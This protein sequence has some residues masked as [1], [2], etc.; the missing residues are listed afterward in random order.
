MLRREGWVDSCELKDVFLFEDISGQGIELEIRENEEEHDH[1]ESG[2]ESDDED[3]D[4]QM[5]V[6]EQ[7]PMQLDAVSD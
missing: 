2:E 4:K 7:E 3:V 5:P 1:A 6:D